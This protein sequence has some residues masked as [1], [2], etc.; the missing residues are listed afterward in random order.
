MVIVNLRVVV[1]PGQGSS[2]EPDVGLGV[3]GLVLFVQQFAV[4]AVVEDG[5]QTVLVD[6][7]DAL[8]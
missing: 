5:G 4:G 1:D 6:F 8:A 2:I 3:A 7:L